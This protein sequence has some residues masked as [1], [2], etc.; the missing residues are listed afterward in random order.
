MYRTC[1]SSASSELASLD[2]DVRTSRALLKAAVSIASHMTLSLYI[3][4][5]RIYHLPE[6]VGCKRL[7]QQPALLVEVVEQIHAVD[8]LPL[9]N[10]CVVP[11]NSSAVRLS[12]RQRSICG[13]RWRTPR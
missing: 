1:Q 13:L 11:S 2:T 8:Q 5:Y 3:S 12:D 9:R 7:R 4:A 10:A 6:Q